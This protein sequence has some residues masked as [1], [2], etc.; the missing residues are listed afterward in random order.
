MLALDQY[1]DPDP[2]DPQ[3]SGLLLDPD[4]DPDPY[5]FIKE[6]KIFQK[7]SSISNTIVLYL[8]DSIFYQWPQKCQL[9]YG[10]D[11]TKPD[12]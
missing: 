4:L 6:L 10:S 9:G 1:S 2:T 7:K 5:S 3:L 12:P 11:L 8:S